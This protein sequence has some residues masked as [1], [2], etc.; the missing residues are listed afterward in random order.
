MCRQS[1]IVLKVA[2]LD[3]ANKWPFKDV[4]LNRRSITPVIEG[5]ISWKELP[6][7]ERLMNYSHGRGSLDFNIPLFDSFSIF[8]SSDFVKWTTGNFFSSN[9]DHAPHNPW[10]SVE[11]CGANHPPARNEHPISQTR[12]CMPWP[13]RR[14]LIKISMLRS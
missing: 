3:G 4:R 2:W 8:F 9:L 11:P 1:K 5:P 14:G 7:K 10:I 12:A 13:V 6:R